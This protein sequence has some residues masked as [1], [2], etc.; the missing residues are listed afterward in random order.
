MVKI[1]DKIDHWVSRALLAVGCL[2]LVLM[3]LHV[4][5]DVVLRSSFHY[6]M[7]GT[8]ETTAYYHMILAVFLPLAYVER[9][10]ESIRVDLFVQWMPRPI[11]LF[12]YQVACLLGLLYFGILAY[13]SFRDA[14][15]AT[16]QLETFMSNFLFYIWP[17]RWALPIGFIAA[18]LAV[19]SCSLRSL[20]QRRPL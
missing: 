4:T 1:I 3:M 18:A 15:R 5:I 16:E 9:Q 2:F 6:Q 11:Q 8:L 7:I 17:S 10:G 13:Q 19:L 14:W 12:L 20:A